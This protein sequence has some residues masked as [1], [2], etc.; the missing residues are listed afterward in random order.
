MSGYCDDIDPDSWSPSNLVKTWFCGVNEVGTNVALPA[1]QGGQEAIQN[2]AED[3]T[4]AANP[5]NLAGAGAGLA[6]GGV[7]AAAGALA[8][9]AAVGLGVAFGADYLFTGGQGTAFLA[10]RVAGRR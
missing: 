7:T 2:V 6:F 5:L 8:V 10:R 3:V 1:V 4:E 9:A